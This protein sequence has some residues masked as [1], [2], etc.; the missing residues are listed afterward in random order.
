MP[1]DRFDLLY[2]IEMTRNFHGLVMQNDY[3][4]LSDR[5]K[6]IRRNI[7]GILNIERTKDE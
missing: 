7:E 1:Q 4:T 6:E 5:I 3:K 2:A